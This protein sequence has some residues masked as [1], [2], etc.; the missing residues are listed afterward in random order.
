MRYLR[1][2][3]PEIYEA[4]LKE[5][6]RQFYHLELIASE[7]FTSL[8][9]M[10]AQGS[11][12][13]NKYAEGL[14]GK[15]YYGG[16][17]FVDVAESLAIER[18]KKLYGAE[19]ANVQPHSGSQANMAVYMAVL[20]PGDVIMGMDLAHGGHLTH[21]AKVNF[22]GKVYHALYYGLNPETELIDY[23]QLWKLA[24]ENKPKLIV[25][26]ASAYPRVI[27]WGR[28]AQIAEE[29]GAYLMVDMAH[30]AGL[31][32][33]GVYPNPVPYA[34]F[35][36]STTHKTLRGPRGGFIL[37]RAA[38]AKDI[39]KTVF[40]GTQGGPLM[41]VI[42]AKAVAFKE[43][44]KKEFK[45]YAEQVVLNA[46]VMAEEFMRLGFK[47]V[48]GGTDSHIVLLDLRNKGIT[49]KEA[50]DAL[51]RANITVNKNAVPFDPLPPTK[52]SGIRI[53]TP[54]MTTRGMKEGEMRLIARLIARVIE[55]LREEKVIE[56]VGKEVVE[57]CRQFPLYPELKE[58]LDELPYSKTAHI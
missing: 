15:R 29:V 41:H 55:N 20:K 10:E 33:G 34:H 11:V 45:D 9:V 2:T 7:N 52:T 32:A 48:T 23:D 54:A 13:T 46:R 12:L 25:A 16:C 43:A 14:P 39:D 26:G 6:E 19:H 53:G 50:E 8:A 49:G 30:Y 51:G 57:L 37:C 27:D 3:D 58:I 4:V 38:F 42:A 47:V 36:T 24:R 40:P 22:S 18:V 21:G 56:G 5:Y 28:F 1:E 31:I 35:V 17:E 44:M